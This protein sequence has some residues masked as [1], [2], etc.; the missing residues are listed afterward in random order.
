MNALND[1]ENEFGTELSI[2]S[3]GRSE[4]DLDEPLSYYVENYPNVATSYNKRL[5]YHT[6]L[7]IFIIIIIIVF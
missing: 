5:S 1:S 2:A 4:D 6:S 7:T 3:D